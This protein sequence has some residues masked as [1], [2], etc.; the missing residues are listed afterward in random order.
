MV[1]QVETVRDGHW[2][3]PDV[4]VF[5]SCSE[6]LC[7]P[8]L[9]H[10]KISSCDLHYIFSLRQ[11]RVKQN[12]ALPPFPLPGFTM[13]WRGGGT[14]DK[15]SDTKNCC[16]AIFTGFCRLSDSC[17]SIHNTQIIFSSMCE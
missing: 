7:V 6:S 9:N 16:G 10:Q 15:V 5:R 12:C 3:Q 13:G 14:K 8:V 4:V 11:D 1:R 2:S 17:H